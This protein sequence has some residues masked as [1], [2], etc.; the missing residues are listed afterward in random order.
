MG[1][2]VVWKRPDVDT[3]VSHIHV[4]EE[5][6]EQVLQQLFGLRLAKIG[7]YSDVDAV[8]K[9][10]VRL[11]KKLGLSEE[12]I[13]AL[14]IIKKTHML[15]TQYLDMLALYRKERRELRRVM[16]YLDEETIEEE[17]ERLAKLKSKVKHLYLQYKERVRKTNNYR[18]ALQRTFESLK[19]LH[20]IPRTNTYK[21]AIGELIKEIEKWLLLGRIDIVKRLKETYLVALTNYALNV[22]LISDTLMQI[23]VDKP[24]DY[25]LRM[26][27]L[28][29]LLHEKPYTIL[30]NLEL[31]DAIA[32]RN[33]HIAV[34]ASKP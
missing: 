15:Y 32:Y 13:K 1:V 34:L 30:N 16:Q 22:Q 2:D 27:A 20:S 29:K 18:K 14:K 28:Q 26:K 21:Y 24:N 19:P 9:S 4:E 5:E 12:E 25:K 17:R 33:A 11:W 7:D 23:M 3:H 31:V 6:F 8:D 10:R